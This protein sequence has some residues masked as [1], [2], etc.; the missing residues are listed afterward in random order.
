MDFDDDGLPELAIGRLPA[1]TAQELSGI[2]TKIIGYEQ[3]PPLTEAVLA[4]DTGFEGTSAQV[5]ALLPGGLTQTPVYHSAFGND[6]LASAALL[7]ALDRGPLLVNYFGHGS[8]GVWQGDLL[9]SEDAPTLMNGLKLPLFLNMTCLNGYFQDL[10]ESLAEALLKAPNGGAVAVWASS[11]LTE[12]EGQV[13]M[14]KEFLHLL[15]NGESLSIG[16]A[17]R[18]GQG[19]DRG[20]G[21]QEDLDPFWGSD[22]ETKVLRTE[23]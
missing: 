10:T 13:A 3:G 21:C 12:P 14:D 6:D 15:F 1:G 2:V 9:V 19:R 11:G 4:A 17:A 18:E 7:A 20:S 16:E 5:G 23:D 8:V 22:D